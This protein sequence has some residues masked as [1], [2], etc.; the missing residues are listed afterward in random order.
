[1]NIKDYIIKLC[2]A[3]GFKFKY[4]L[5]RYLQID[6]YYTQQTY[7]DGLKVAISS[8]PLDSY[9]IIKNAKEVKEIFEPWKKEANGRKPKELNRVGGTKEWEQIKKRMKIIMAHGFVYCTHCGKKIK[10]ERAEYKN[11]F[12]YQCSFHCHIREIDYI[13]K[14]TEALR[15]EK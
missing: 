15:V 7:P 1:M 13:F 14:I 5:F 10:Y 4:E 12:G 2:W 8:I 11:T 6:N 3:N 9:F